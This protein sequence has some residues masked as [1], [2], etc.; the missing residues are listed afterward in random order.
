MTMRSPT[1]SLAL[2]PP[3]VDL[4]NEPLTLGFVQLRLDLVIGELLDLLGGV[5]E[6]L[7]DR[8]GVRFLRGVIAVHRQPERDRG[9][10]LVL[11]SA[12][13]GSLLAHARATAELRQAFHKGECRSCGVSTKRHRD[14]AGDS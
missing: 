14:S 10:V 12:L 8:A 1:I 9:V 13:L 4:P 7:A 2:V 6:P 11:A 5:S 3:V